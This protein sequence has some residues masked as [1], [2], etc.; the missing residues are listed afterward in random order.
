LQR[1]DCILGIIIFLHKVDH[2][3]TLEALVENVSCVERESH[4]LKDN[5]A[6]YIS[7]REMILQ[8]P[9][10]R[11]A[12]TIPLSHS[13]LWLRRPSGVALPIVLF[14]TRL[15]LRLRWLLLLAALPWL[16]FVDRP[17]MNLLL[18]TVVSLPK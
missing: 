11:G 10:F 6:M 5:G 1:R 17:W 14:V 2:I 3:I 8:T 9:V 7:R 4:L 13:E 18:L 12:A 16:L 15:V